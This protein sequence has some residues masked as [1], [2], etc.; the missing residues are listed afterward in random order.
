LT[1][2]LLRRK[3]ESWTISRSIHPGRSQLRG[4][5][6]YGWRHTPG[7]RRMSV[8]RNRGAGES[9]RQLRSLVG[10]ILRGLSPLGSLQPARGPC[11]NGNEQGVT[12]HRRLPKSAY[13]VGVHQLDGQSRIEIFR[14]RVRNQ[15]AATTQPSSTIQRCAARWQPYPSHTAQR[16]RGRYC[17][18]PAQ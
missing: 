14:L 15:P 10:V 11:D 9:S 5:H 16:D 13:I 18:A 3:T 4:V 17:C 8:G 2:A 6:H 12:R 7:L 1:R